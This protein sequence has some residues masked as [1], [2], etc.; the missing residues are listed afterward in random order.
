MLFPQSVHAT[1]HTA[2]LVRHKILITYN[3][4]PLTRKFWLLSHRYSLIHRGQDRMDWRHFAADIYKRIFLNENIW[5]PIKISL[6]FIPNG[7]FNNIPVLVKIMAW[8]RTGDK[9]L[10]DSMM[11]SLP[12]HICLTRPQWVNS[13]IYW[14]QTHLCYYIHG[15]YLE[16]SSETADL[17]SQSDVYRTQQSLFGLFSF[18]HYLKPIPTAAG[19]SLCV[20]WE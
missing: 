6:T 11:V 13:Y 1:R 15:W 5:I 8:R 10:S 18:L 7:P 3:F 19:T 9:P 4:A 17:K 16:S 20:Y 12:T 14:S 2:K